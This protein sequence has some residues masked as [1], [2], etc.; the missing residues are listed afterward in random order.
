MESILQKLSIEITLLESLDVYE[1]RARWRVL[2][3]TEAPTRFSQDQLMRAVAYR[4]H[5]RLLGALNL[6]RGGS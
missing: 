4:M 2:Y 3:E 6:P 1:L 5:E